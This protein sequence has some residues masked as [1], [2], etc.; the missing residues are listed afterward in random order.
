[1]GGPYAIF[2]G[3]VCQVFCRNPLILTDFYAVQTP[4]YGIFLGDIFCKHGGWGWS[5]L[6]SSL[7]TVL[8]GTKV[9][10]TPWA[11]TPKESEKRPEESTMAPLPQPKKEGPIHIGPANWFTIVTTSITDRIKFS[12]N[13]FLQFLTGSLPE[14]ISS[15]LI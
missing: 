7:R 2:L 6:F 8:P 15:E 3:S 5:E 1:M 12:V 10:Q 11:R 13:Y 4:L 14:N 9:S